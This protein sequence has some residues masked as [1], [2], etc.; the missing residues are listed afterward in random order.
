MR[1]VRNLFPHHLGLVSDFSFPCTFQPTFPD[2]TLSVWRVFR[3]FYFMAKITLN[4]LSFEAPDKFKAGE[5]LSVSDAKVLNYLWREKAERELKKYLLL[6]PFAS[7][8][9]LE[10]QLEFVTLNSGPSNLELQI[11][12]ARLVREKHLKPT[13]AEDAAYKYLSAKHLV[14]AKILGRFNR[15]N[16]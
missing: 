10:L 1:S 9:D 16:S 8:A 11:E 15:T 2:P 7:K 4:S 6:F 13:E 5:R 14:V 3:L 12:V